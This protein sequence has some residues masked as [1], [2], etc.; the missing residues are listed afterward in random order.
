MAHSIE[1]ENCIMKT[2]FAPLFALCLLTFSRNGLAQEAEATA[3]ATPRPAILS[4]SSVGNPK[5]APLTV[6]V[7][8]SGGARITGTLTDVVLLPVRTSFGEAS[9]PFSEI[10]GVKL[11]SADDSSTT[12]ILKNGDSITGATDLKVV[13]VETEWGSAKINGSSILSI[14]LLPDLKWNATNG[15]SGRRWSLVDSKQL[16]NA[17]QPG[18][19]GT[20]SSAK[21]SVGSTQSVP[22]A[23]IRN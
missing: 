3:V 5:I 21:P 7:E 10:A 23:P 6:S 11:A 22:S 16:A 9:V 18:N 8:L 2:R 4:G 15:L 17:S 14:L 12:V 20:V 19:N 1:L 13:S